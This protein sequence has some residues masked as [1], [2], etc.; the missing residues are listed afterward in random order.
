MT[1]TTTKSAFTAPKFEMPKFEIPSF[2]MPK[3]EV[4]AAFREAAEKGV[5]Q[6]K[7]CVS[8]GNLLKHA[9]VPQA[10]VDS[11]AANSEA[12]LPD[13]LIGALEAG[14]AA[15]GE[16]GPVHSAG[17]IVVHEQDWPLVDLRVDW[18]DDDPIAGL[19]KLWESYRTQMNDYV[20][21]ALN[22]SAAPS[23]GV[24]GDPGR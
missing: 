11:F 23:Y 17:V 5:A 2:D 8:G 16:A 9:G 18:A 4:P 13:R 20:T 21:R 6:A 24:P 3:F 1:E 22:P 12:A 15:G 19:R 14:L 10:I 7:D